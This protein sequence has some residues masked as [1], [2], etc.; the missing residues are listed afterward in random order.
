ML[1]LSPELENGGRDGLPAKVQAMWQRIAEVH[2]ETHEW[3]IKVRLG[4][5]RNTHGKG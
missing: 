5:S 3:F 2:L 1:R 4:A